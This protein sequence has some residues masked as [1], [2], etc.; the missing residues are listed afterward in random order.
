MFTAS[1]LQS[2]G[3]YVTN[4][5]K[6]RMPVD[7]PTVSKVNILKRVQFNMMLAGSASIAAMSDQDI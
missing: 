5:G 4:L 6:K 2:R 7:M 1:D 3:H